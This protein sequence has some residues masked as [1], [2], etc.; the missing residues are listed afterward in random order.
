MHYKNYFWKKGLPAGLQK[1]EDP[2]SEPQSYKIVSDPYKKRISIE[3]Y[4]NGIFD[5]LLYDS[6]I[7]DFRCLNEQ[8]QMGWQKQT[9]ASSPEKVVTAISDLNDRVIFLE[10]HFFKSSLCVKCEVYS[11]HGWLASIHQ[12]NY[13]ALGHEFNGVILYDRGRRP[14]LKKI[15]EV[16]ENEE[17]TELLEE[18]RDFAG[19]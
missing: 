16:D 19:E 12:M 6:L 14:V 10:H 3:S 11:P 9:L 1:I 13:Q 4:K 18:T 17:F 7:L 2:I 15:Y 5:D 8:Q